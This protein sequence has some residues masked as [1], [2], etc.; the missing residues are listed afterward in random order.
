MTDIAAFSV[1]EAVA[2]DAVVVSELR[3][4]VAA[5][6]RWLGTEPPVDVDDFARRFL[7]VLDADSSYAV[8]AVDESGT[9]I[10]F[11]AVF[12]VLPGVTT[13]GMAVA[14]QWRRRG[15]GGALVDALLAWSRRRDAH[16]VILEVWPHNEAAIGLYSSRGFVRE[17][18]RRSHYRR[19][20][21]ELWD[22]VEMGLI[23]GE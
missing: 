7:D 6:G 15:V 5:E 9:V 23:L 2:D 19:R 12:T 16:K 4:R 14:L 22:V 8:V 21:G 18:L 20:N 10:G 17:G 13:F 3:A 1:R 11:V